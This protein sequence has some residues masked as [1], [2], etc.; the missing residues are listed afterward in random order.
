M[1]W[2][3]SWPTSISLAMGG[4]TCVCFLLQT[5][6][7]IPSLGLFSCESHVYNKPSFNTCWAQQSPT[8]EETS[9]N[10]HEQHA[11]RLILMSRS[12]QHLLYRWLLWLA[13]SDVPGVWY[14]IAG[15]FS[16]VLSSDREVAARKIQAKT[17]RMEQD[18]AYDYQSTSQD[19]F[20]VY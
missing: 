13:R 10:E 12:R 2:A 19:M 3:I 11:G 6:A 15:H 20:Y 17:W 18:I 14:S 1:P 4:Y 5:Q 8:D 7:A 9:P 16:C